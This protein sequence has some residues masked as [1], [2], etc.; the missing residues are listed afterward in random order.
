MPF[1]TVET[2]STYTEGNVLF[3]VNFIG[4]GCCKCTGFELLFPQ[5]FSCVLIESTKHIIP[6]GRNKHQTA[7]CNDRP[8]Q[9]LGACWR[10]ST[11]CELDRESTRLN[12]SYV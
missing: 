11:G 2:I 4:T 7:C 3:T 10:N 12:S 5:N 6:C 1:R 9:I 8:P